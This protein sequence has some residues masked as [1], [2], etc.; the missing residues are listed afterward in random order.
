MELDEPTIDDTTLVGR[1]EPGG[2]LRQV[3]LS[4]EPLIDRK[5]RVKMVRLHAA[6]LPGRKM[7]SLLDL[8]RDVGAALTPSAKPILLSAAGE[9]VEVRKTPANYNL[10]V[11]L[12]GEFV[13]AAHGPQVVSSLRDARFRLALR[14]RHDDQLSGSLRSAFACTIVDYSEFD[15]RSHTGGRGHAQMAVSGVQ[16]IAQ[17]QAAFDAGISACVGWPFKD[18]ISSRRASSIS[19]SFATITELL[20]R[21]EG[22]DDIGVLENVIRQDPALAYRLLQMINSAAF[23]LRVEITSFRHCIMMLGYEK[24]KRWLSLLLS[25]SSHEATTRPLMF[26]SFIRGILLEKLASD[27][28]DEQTGDDLFTLGVF[29][30]ID[31]IFGKPIEQLLDSLHVAPE[32]RS[33][34][35]KNEGR[36][37]SYLRVVRALEGGVT[38]DILNQ[39]DSNLLS[40]RE[41]NEKLLATLSNPFF[42]VEAQAEH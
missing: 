11:E 34:L 17:M 5:W 42:P 10:L 39:L 13:S 19:P 36:Y 21:I 33:A 8:Y 16:S 6:P 40:V 27:S 24:L 4:Y 25:I 3:V 20:G 14:A 32:I 38:S 2:S 26:A 28:G 1:G 31:K 37:A 15:G 22:G 7:P 23:G 35:Q 30:L 9:Y 18:P 41:C 29:S 12:P